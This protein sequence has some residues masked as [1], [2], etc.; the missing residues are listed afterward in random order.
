M[1]ENTRN[2]QNEI[3]KLNVGRIN[4]MEV[5]GTHTMSI[6][7]SGLKSLLPENIN[8]LS[9]PG[10]P[11]CVTP[12]EI[13]DSILELADKDGVVIA[14]Y[15]DMVRV[16]GTE[17][18]LSLEKKRSE[19]SDVRVV[20]SPVDAVNMAASEPEKEVVFL[21]VGFETTAPGTAAAVHLAKEKGLKNFTVL[22]LLKRVEPALKALISSPGF[23]VQGFI[24]PGHV[25]TII[26]TEGFRFLADEYKIPSVVTG[27]EPEDILLGIYMI[28]KQIAL[29]QPEM[30]NEYKRAVSL[31]GNLLSKKMMEET[32]TE[33]AALWRGLGVIEKSALFLNEKYAGFDAAKRFGID[34]IPKIKPTPCRC[35]DVIQGKITPRKC[36]LFG[37]VCE[38][39]NP[40]GPCMVSGEGTCAAAYKYGT[41]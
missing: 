10:C 8:L 14:T 34:Y 15:G 31:Q 20:Y 5:C 29:G 11:V 41:F 35:G 23:N 36:P 9:G 37:K 1:N 25:A 33:G 24:C 2:L 26:G 22:S 16:P 19:G 32:F 28:L 3:R 13:I 17:R 30:Q 27:F 38:P 4:L 6:A 12:A 18:G 7:K 39:E 40:M 21:G